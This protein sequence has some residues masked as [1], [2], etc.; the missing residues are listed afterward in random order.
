[1]TKSSPSLRPCNFP[2]NSPHLWHILR[3]DL[4]LLLYAKKLDLRGWISTPKRDSPLLRE[5]FFLPHQ[6]RC[7]LHTALLTHCA[8]RIVS[9]TLVSRR[10]VG[11][12]IRSNQSRLY[13]PQ[14]TENGL[15]AYTLHWK[16][17]GCSAF[18]LIFTSRCD[19]VFVHLFRWRITK[20]FCRIRFEMQNNIID[21]KNANLCGKLGTI[22]NM[23]MVSVAY[24][25][26]Y[27]SRFCMRLAGWGKRK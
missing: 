5:I 3:E 21:R 2:E 17:F 20:S 15:S 9:C 22:V 18:A 23:I 6:A 10:V 24:V 27:N 11:S 4:P 1:M 7:S 13:E 12:H 19:S 16:T 26:V 8:K 14:C 25:C